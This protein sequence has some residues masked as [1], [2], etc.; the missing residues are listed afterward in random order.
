MWQQW[1]RLASRLTTTLLDVHNV[2][3][4]NE[5]DDGRRRRLHLRAVVSVGGG[6]RGQRGQMAGC[7][8]DDV[9]D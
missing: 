2:E 8:V 7:Y 4:A 5:G 9:D 3:V 1:M 6:G